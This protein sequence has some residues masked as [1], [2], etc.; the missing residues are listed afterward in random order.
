MIHE[1]F[2]WCSRH[3]L[4]L[5]PGGYRLVAAVAVDDAYGKDAVAFLA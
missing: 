4:E 2:A 3:V 1:A 5:S